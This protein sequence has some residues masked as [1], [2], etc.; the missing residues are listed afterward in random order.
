MKK[1]IGVTLLIVCALG[2]FINSIIYQKGLNESNKSVTNDSY[3]NQDLQEPKELTAEQ[4]ADQQMAD[5]YSPGT[6]NRNKIQVDYENEPGT[7]TPEYTEQKRS[8]M[9][10]PF[11]LL[12]ILG[13]YFVTRKEIKN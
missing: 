9:F 6:S 10:I 11:I 7:L 5:F 1:V 8:E 3:T 4:M 12:G 2:I 13:I